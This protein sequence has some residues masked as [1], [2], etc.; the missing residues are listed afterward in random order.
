MATGSRDFRATIGYS[1]DPAGERAFV[2]ANQRLVAELDKTR[3]QQLSVEQAAESMNKELANIARAKAIDQIALQARAAAI[4]TGRWR[5][6]IALASRSLSDV[7]ASEAEIKR[8]TKQI[9]DAAQE[10]NLLFER[11]QAV[12]REIATTPD[13]SLGGSAG[14]IARGGVGGGGRGRLGQLGTQLFLLPDIGIPGLPGGLSTT[15]LS[16]GMILAD[17]A[18]VQLGVSATALATGLGLVGGAAIVF[19]HAI[20]EVQK[21]LEEAK[22]AADRFAQRTAT[23]ADLIASGATTPDVTLQRDRIREALGVVNEEV[24]ALVTRRDRLRELRFTTDPAEVEEFNRLFQEVSAI[25]GSNVTDFQALQEAIDAVT[26]KSIDYGGKL[27]DLNSLLASG[28]LAANDA[29][30]AT[31]RLVESL[32][33][34]ADDLAELVRSNIAAQAEARAE[35]IAG[36]FDFRRR[37]AELRRTGTQEQIDELRQLNVEEFQLNQQLIDQLQVLA[38]SS[39]TVAQEVE[40][41][42]ARQAELIF[43]NQLLASEVEPVVGARDR[44]IAA[45]QALKDQTD[46]YFEALTNTTKAQQ[47]LLDAQQA[48]N[49]VLAE[50]DARLVEIA[51]NLAEREAE[52]AET[53]AE[54]IEEVEER[55]GE[56]RAKRA[57]D[58]SKRIAKIERDFARSFTEAVGARDAL[59]A[60][61]AKQRRADALKDLQEGQTEQ[62]KELEVSLQKQLKTIERNYEKQLDAARKA[63]E[64]SERQERARRDRELAIAQRAIDQADVQLRNA[65]NA[66]LAIY[67][68]H[69][70]N[71]NNTANAGLNT[72]VN[73]FGQGLLTMVQQTQAAFSRINPTVARAPIQYSSPIGPQRNTIGSGFIP[74]NSNPFQLTNSQQTV[75]NFNPTIVG[76]SPQQ[77]RNAAFAALDKAIDQ[78]TRGGR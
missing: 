60:E 26:Q 57:E 42:I 34:A 53:R 70:A 68:T 2:T 75:F 62:E 63:A 76:N 77:L 33:N 4:E 25:V 41:L 49:D 65:K 3:K 73:T 19:G 9:A 72:L 13:V 20:G 59:A 71:L 15:E 52:A 5:D 61:Q 40:R 21:E 78:A 44:E 74:V 43:Q 37:A 50:S 47:E 12:K 36:E 1:Y 55:V 16:R 8:V 38:P 23:N 18:M 51:A 64:K 56:Q 67:Q 6:G 24:E 11:Y 27:F 31:T 32:R 35:S 66:E 28:E 14:G 54:R 48:Y 46:E 58:L 39:K 22:A 30:E 7:G 45:A 29:A 10:T 69:F 17:T